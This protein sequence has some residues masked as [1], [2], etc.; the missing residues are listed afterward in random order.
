MFGFI[1]QWVGAGRAIAIAGALGCLVAS[2]LQFLGHS[3]TRSVAAAQPVA[4]RNGPRYTPKTK[5]KGH[6]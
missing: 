4:L 6:S 5:E 1:G 2:A 3:A